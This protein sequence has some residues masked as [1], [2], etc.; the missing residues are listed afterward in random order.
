MAPYG[1]SQGY[2]AMTTT[3]AYPSYLPAAVPVTLPPMNHF[4]D[5]IKSNG[6]NLSPYM[7]YGYIAGMDVG[8]ANSYDHSNPHVSYKRHP[9][10][11][12]DPRC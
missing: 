1:S 2:P 11:S 10:P 5:A 7:N 12:R 6:D 8:S 3:E 9:P 4:S